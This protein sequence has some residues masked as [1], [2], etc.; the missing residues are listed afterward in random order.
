M[1]NDSLGSNY[2]THLSYFEYGL[3]LPRFK[4]RINENGPFRGCL[5]QWMDD[6]M[7]MCVV[8]C[9]NSWS[10]NHG[11]P[12]ARTC[13]CEVVKLAFTYCLDVLLVFSSCLPS[14]EGAQGF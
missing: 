9:V 12:T 3:S 10:N 6:C 1:P 11:L 13:L 4:S 7:C 8:V 2:V 5:E 14:D